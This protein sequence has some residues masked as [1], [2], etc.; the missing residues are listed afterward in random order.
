MALFVFPLEGNPQIKIKGMFFVFCLRKLISAN[1]IVLIKSEINLKDKA[2]A[3][4]VPVLLVP[5][6]IRKLTN[7]TT[8]W[9]GQVTDTPRQ[10]VLYFYRKMS[11]A[12]TMVLTIDHYILA[13]Q[14]KFSAIFTSADKAC[15]TYPYPTRWTDKKRITARVV[16]TLVV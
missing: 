10:K 13:Y 11:L 8:D 3:R 15:L 6:R 2:R 16:N 5:I 7:K 12:L 14:T 9:Q 1:R 4:M